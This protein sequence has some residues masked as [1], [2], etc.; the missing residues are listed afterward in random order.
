MVAAAVDGGADDAGDDD[1]DTVFI[2]GLCLVFTQQV[3]LV[4]KKGRSVMAVAAESGQL[5]TMRYLALTQVRRAS[6]S[7]SYFNSRFG[8]YFTRD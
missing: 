1:H 6:R 4:D 7:V 8:A 5:A 2:V 3:A